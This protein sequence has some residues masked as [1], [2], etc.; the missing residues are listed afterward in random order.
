[1][2]IISNF[3]D[4]YD[5]CQVFTEDLI[6]IRNP[7]IEETDKVSNIGSYWN[8]PLNTEII[9]IGFC[10]KIYFCIKAYLNY[11]WG[12]TKYAEKYCYDPDTLNNFIEEYV[13]DKTLRKIK[14]K[15]YTQKQIYKLW[16]NTHLW[17]TKYEVPIFIETNLRNKKHYNVKN[18]KWNKL[19]R[20]YNGNL[21]FYDFIKIFPP[22]QAY[23]ELR[24]YMSNMA[25]PN[26]PIPSVSDADMLEAKGFDLKTSFRKE[27]K[28]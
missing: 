19:Y 11:G 15:E 3:K 18:Y 28:K 4:Y 17:K 20:I 10:G 8:I 2:R 1:M 16:E 7:I 12:H 22:Y 9:R 27:K 5:C 24:M 6:Y 14:Y 26:K 23:Q 25:F 13:D 21:R